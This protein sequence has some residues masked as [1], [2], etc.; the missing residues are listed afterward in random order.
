MQGKQSDSRHS[1]QNYQENIYRGA[2]SAN[3]YTRVSDKR[4]MPQKN[5]PTTNSGNISGIQNT[6]ANQSY[7]NNRL[8]P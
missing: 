5:L 2:G 7:R 8:G 1:S 6:S 3:R 4:G